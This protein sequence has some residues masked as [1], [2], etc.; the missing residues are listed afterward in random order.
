MPTQTLFSLFSQSKRLF[1]LSSLTLFLSLAG[2]S[3]DTQQSMPNFKLSEISGKVLTQDDFKNK[4]TII[5][6][7][8]TSCTS[9]VKE[10]PQLIET[11]EKFKADGVELM[12]VA[13]SY[14]PPM[15]VVN[16]AQ[17]RKLPFKVALD[18]D[19]SVAKAFG[20]IQLTPTT[21][22]INKKGKII[23]RYVGEPEWDAF[24]QLIQ[25][26]LAE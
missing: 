23:K 21:L 9:C 5:N 4:V 11:Y 15:Y 3:S 14:D 13:M 17:T 16:F 18:S 24:H 7:W 8:A 10:M 25:K 1:L 12:A 6:F 2:C 20:K 26:S 22:V 19:G